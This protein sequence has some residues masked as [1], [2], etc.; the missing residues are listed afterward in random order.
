MDKKLIVDEI[1]EK[2]AR[3]KRK[4]SETI[5]VPVKAVRRVIQQS[6]QL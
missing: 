3:N 4:K 2:S 5:P 6:I 1:N